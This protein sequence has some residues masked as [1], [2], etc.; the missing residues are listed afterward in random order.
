MRIG[1]GLGVIPLLGVILN[2]LHIPIDWK[3]FLVLSIII[4]V[5]N[6]FR[7]RNSIKIPSIKLTKS[8][9]AVIL[10]LVMFFLTLFMYV[11]GSFVYPY[12][13][14]DDPWTHAKGIKYV[15]MEKNVRDT[16]NVFKYIDPYPPGFA[17]LF[18]VLHQTSSSLMWTMKFFNA[19]IISLGVLF[20]YFF[21]KQFV[22]NRNK[23]LLSTSIFVMV[24]CYLSHFIWSHSLVVTC[25]F[26]LMYSIGRIREDSRW[27]YAFM[28]VYSGIFLI[29]PTQA[30]KISILVGIYLVVFSILK[31]KVQWNVLFAMIGGFLLSLLWW[32]NKIGAMFGKQGK[33]AIIFSTQETNFI[34]QLIGKLARAFPSNS[35]TATRAYTFNDF[36]VAK[37]QNLINNPIGVGIVLSIL[38]FLSLII[39]LRRYKSLADEKNHWIS[40]A[41]L[42]LLFTFIGINSVTFNLPVGLFAFRFWMLFAIPL[43]LIAAHGFVFIVELLKQMK[44]PKIA[45]ISLIIILIFLTSGQ[46]KYTLN[47]AMWLPGGV[48]TSN[49]EVSGYMWLKTLPVNTKVFSYSGDEIVIGLDKFSCMWCDNLIEFRK[50]LLYQNVS[51]LYNWLKKEK[52]QY[53]VMDSMSY[54]DLVR[55][56]GENETNELLPK[57]L[58]EIISSEKFQVVHQTKSMV[59]FKL[60]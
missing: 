44:V 10:V 56:F 38:L 3:I 6:M 53:L 17:V 42:W 35:G 50:D 43:S 11:K 46:Q 7:F 39:I 20:F 14:D 21:A 1:F 30:I 34:T 32:Y 28:L 16:N 25:F 5:Y 29:Q 51:E 52:Y 48:W 4:P 36:F 33:K 60:L 31:K 55:P 19:L 24:P 41:L 57:R 22:G 2:L 40:V 8:N 26:P 23:A 54:R 18:G 47:T 49:D 45:T 58:Q 37:S 59:V 12:L 9:I 15:T 13:E 27:K